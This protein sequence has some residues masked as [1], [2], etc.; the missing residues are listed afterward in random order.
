[1]LTYRFRAH[2]HILV[3]CCSFVSKGFPP[4]PIQADRAF[5]V[6]KSPPTLAVVVGQLLGTVGSVPTVPTHRPGALHTV[7]TVL[8][9][10]MIGI[11]FFPF[12]VK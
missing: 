8:S 12:E 3:C 5:F 11:P 10:N 4:Q 7:S 1:M 6:A 2:L 9:T